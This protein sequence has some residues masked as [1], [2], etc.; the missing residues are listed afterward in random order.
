MSSFDM[1]HDIVYLILKLLV[2]S[3]D[4]VNLAVILIWRIWRILKIRQIKNTP[5]EIMLNFSDLV[6]VYSAVCMV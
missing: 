5:I 6:T 2:I 1:S 3:V 4:R